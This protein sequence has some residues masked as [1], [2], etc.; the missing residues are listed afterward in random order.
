MPKPLKLDGGRLKEFLSSDA[1]QLASVRFDATN[2]PV[3]PP[4]GTAYLYV[5]PD[6]VIYLLDDGGNETALGGGD[7]T[8]L[9]HELLFRIL[10]SLHSLNARLSAAGM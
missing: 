6:K 4:S 1:L 7:A 2:P 3:A 10:L 8:D 5:K 9:T